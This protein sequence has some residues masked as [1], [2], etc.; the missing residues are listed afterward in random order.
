MGPCRIST[1]FWQDPK[2]SRLKSHLSSIGVHLFFVLLFTPH[3]VVY[4]L[5]PPFVTHTAQQFQIRCIPMEASGA[6][7]LQTPRHFRKEIKF[8]VLKDPITLRA[9]CFELVKIFFLSTPSNLS[10]FSFGLTPR[11]HPR[12]R[13]WR[14]FRFPDRFSFFIFLIS[15]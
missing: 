4:L 2:S 15:R 1:E 7:A 8:Q 12:L 6:G 9:A 5:Q 10:Y 3:S 14:T 11:Q 13:L